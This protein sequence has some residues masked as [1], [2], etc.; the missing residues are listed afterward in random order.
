MDVKPSGKLTVG[1]A[2]QLAKANL[3][4]LFSFEGKVMEVSDSHAEK[5]SLIISVI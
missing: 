5:V 2:L 1:N 3:P 4:M